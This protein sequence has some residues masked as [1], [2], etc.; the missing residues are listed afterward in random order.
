V[1]V[2][3]LCNGREDD[4]FKEFDQKFFHEIDNALFYNI[5]IGSYILERSNFEEL[6]EKFKKITVSYFAKKLKD[7]HA[8]D[9]KFAELPVELFDDEEI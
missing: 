3:E 5:R 8:S 4:R 9:Q 6:F 7:D 2:K 1:K